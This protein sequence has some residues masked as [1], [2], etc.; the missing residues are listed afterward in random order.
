[1][2]IY[3]FGVRIKELREQRHLSQTRAAERLNVTRSTISAY[4]RNTKTPRVEVLANM[5]ILYH[6]SVDYML[7]L[8]NR[9]S[10]YLDDLT[11]RQRQTVLD[12][13]K[14]LKDE[15]HSDQCDTKTL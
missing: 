15:F 11:P 7:G 4:E 2:M 9:T 10:L 8:E 5:A 1:M 3:D 12:I 6:T 13:V 14:L